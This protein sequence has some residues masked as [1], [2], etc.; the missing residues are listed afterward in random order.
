MTTPFDTVTFAHGPDMKNRFM[1]APLTNQQSH[2]DGTLSDD[3]FRW[4]VMRAEGGFG[5]TMT[6]ASHVQANG[7]GFTGQLGCYSDQHVEGLARLARAITSHGSLAIVQLHHAGMRSPAELIGAAPVAPFDDDVT[8]ARALTTEEVAEVVE[9]FVLAAARVQ[10]AGFDGVELHG[11]H[12]YLLCQFL[13]ATHN[14]RDDQYGGSSENRSRIFFEIIA[15][16]RAR[17]GEDF[18]L[19]VRLSPERFDV[20]T[21]DI[22]ELYQRLVACGDVDLIDL[23]LWNV[24]KEAIDEEFAGQPLL[25]LFTGLERGSTR[26]AAAGRIYSGGDVNRAL[27]SGVDVVDIGRAAITNHDFPNRVRGDA[28]FAMRTLPVPAEVL[29]SEGMGEEF[30]TYMR[31]WSGF[32]GE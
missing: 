28:T 16:I 19:G 23:S 25:E 6:C 24:F 32:V 3:E 12:G 29:R 11:A 10:R 30:L 20:A 26:L 4:L 8:G 27:A 21:V 15:A 1:L 2:D 14:H 7:R 31:Q 17:C 18:H 9:S 13:D 22:L 5:M